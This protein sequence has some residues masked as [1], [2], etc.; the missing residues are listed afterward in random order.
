MIIQSNR[1]HPRTQEDMELQRHSHFATHVNPACSLHK[2]TNCLLYKLPSLLDWKRKRDGS[3]K[4]PKVQKH[5][6][7]LF[8]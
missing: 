1:P 8:V 7:A 5:R 3:K 6:V 2:A 4:D